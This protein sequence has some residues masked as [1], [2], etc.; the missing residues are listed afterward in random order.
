MGEELV[1]ARTLSQGNTFW[2]SLAEIFSIIT[3]LAFL[4]SVFLHVVVFGK[5]GLSYLQLATPSD[6]L[7]GGLAVLVHALTFSPIIVF[8][9][10][11]GFALGSKGKLRRR[12]ATIVT[13]ALL[14]SGIFIEIIGKDYFVFLIIRGTFLLITFTCGTIVGIIW[15]WDSI[16]SEYNRFNQRSVTF[17]SIGFIFLICIFVT[18]SDFT[19]YGFDENLAVTQVAS[20]KGEDFPCRRPRALWIG[21]KAI[22]IDCAN[23]TTGVAKPEIILVNGPIRLSR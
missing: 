19:N 10:A 20:L 18:I 13:L 22:I 2:Q 8:G 1:A 14:I 16:Q 21:E 5:W 12:V 4:G 6:V 9:G 23:L 3:A 15:G 11:F 7:M 17:A